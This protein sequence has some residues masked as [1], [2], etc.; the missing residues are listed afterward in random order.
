MS[1]AETES[2][3]GEKDKASK[4]N[5]DHHGLLHHID[6]AALQIKPTGASSELEQLF[7]KALRTAGQIYELRAPPRCLIYF[8]DDFRPLGPRSSRTPLSIPNSPELAPLFS[9]HGTIMIRSVPGSPMSKEIGA[10]HLIACAPLRTP[11]GSL[12]GVLA[13]PENWLSSEM[14]LSQLATKLGQIAFHLSRAY[15]QYEQVNRAAKLERLWSSLLK[16]KLSPTACYRALAEQLHEL[17]PD[18]GPLCIQ[19]VPQSQILMLADAANDVRRPEHLIIRGTTGLE[20]SGTRLAIDRSI[21]GL[22]VADG[23]VE[24]FLDDPSKPQYSSLYRNYFQGRNQRARTEMVVRLEHEGLIL[25]LLN[26]ESQ[27]SRAFSYHHLEALRDYGPTIAHIA[28]VLEQRLNMNTEMQ[29]SVASSTRQ[30]LD[31]LAKIF[32]HGI[33]TPVMT[34]VLNTNALEK[35]T[36]DSEK[37]TKTL[38]SG[39]TSPTAPVKRAIES[40]RVTGESLRRVH[41]RLL[42]DHEQLSSYSDDFAAE[43]DSYAVQRPMVI[44]SVIDNAMQLANNALLANNT[45]KIRFKVTRDQSGSTTLINCSTLIKQHLYSVFHN[46]VDSIVHRMEH[47]DRPGEVTLKITSES[48]P[49]KQERQLN[50]SWVVRI[51]DNGI[52]VPGHQLEDLRRFEPGTTFKSS[53]NGHGLTAAQRYFASI[54]GR[55]ELNSEEGKYFEVALYF[56]EYRPDETIQT[57]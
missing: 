22:V 49:A 32:R 55:I 52:G 38:S 48:P 8:Y 17:L 21:C 57:T 56:D 10:D 45:R 54:G 2:L 1:V 25:G 36:D 44:R 29:Q 50:R 30:Y 37:A 42:A 13:V 19:G 24:H 23:A 6:Q 27:K 39:V 9:R 28:A 34:M 7:L 40:L 53:G 47:D 51:R 18:F 12:L 33:R 20:H 43:I 14:T 3:A 5:V 15:A 11:R 46:C 31:G 41:K 35:L 26:L 4:W 16:Q